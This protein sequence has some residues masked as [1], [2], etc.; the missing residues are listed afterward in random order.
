MSQTN[1][2]SMDSLDSSSHLTAYLQAKLYRGVID[3]VMNAMREAFSEEGVDEQV[4]LDLKATWERR[5]AESKA[6]DSK[7]DSEAQLAVTAAGSSNSAPARGRA[8]NRAAA[9]AAAAAAQQ[10]QFDQ[11]TLNPY[12]QSPAAA[13]SA[14]R[15]SGLV[16]Q[17]DGPHD[18]SDEDE[19]EE[20]GK[21]EPDEQEDNE[22]EKNE[23]ENDSPGEEEEPL[24]SGDDVS[25]E[26]PNELFETDN[27]VVCQYDKVSTLF[28]NIFT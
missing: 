28:G 2:V 20:D 10:Q 12:Q 7:S 17:L 27:V 6:I 22:D 16:V 18:S 8:A 26:E 15:T 19:D 9:A 4:L 1:V 23:E 25:D 5:L 24:N 14:G 3:D 11:N 13:N 21:D